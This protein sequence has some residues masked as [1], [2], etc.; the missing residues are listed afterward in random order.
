MNNNSWLLFWTISLLIAGAS[1][2]FISVV[3]AI[4]GFKDLREM[5]SRL[6]QQNDQP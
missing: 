2:A 5:F 1:F 6:D 4:R 3:V